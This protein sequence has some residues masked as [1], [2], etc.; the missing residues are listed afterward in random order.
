MVAGTIL[1]HFPLIADITG[2][3]AVIDRLETAVDTLRDV[4]EPD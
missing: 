1:N 2:I 3:D 4:I